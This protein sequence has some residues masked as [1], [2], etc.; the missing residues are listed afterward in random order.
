MMRDALDILNPKGRFT[1]TASYYPEECDDPSLGAQKFNYE[2]VSPYSRAWKILFGNIQSFDAG[3]TAIRTNDNLGFKVNG[4]VIT[5]DGNAF[6]I[7]SIEK[8]YQSANKQVMRIFGTPVSVQY[9]LRLVSDENPW[10]I[11]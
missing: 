7:V 5:Q 8:D 11:V 4:I 10:G 9:L 1:A 6:R 2:Y 3:E